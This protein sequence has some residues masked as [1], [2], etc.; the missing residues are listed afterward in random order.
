MNPPPPSP[1]GAAQQPPSPPEA[2]AAETAIAANMEASLP[3]A[4]ISGSTPIKSK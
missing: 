1:V 4:G 3:A 2:A